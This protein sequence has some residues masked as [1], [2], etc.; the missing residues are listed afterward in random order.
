[1]APRKKLE[2]IVEMHSVSAVEEALAQCGA[3]GWSVF[4]G[5]QGAGEAGRW[6]QSGISATFEMCMIIAVVEEAVCSSVLERLAT[7]FEEYPGIVAVSDV[8]VI[9]GNKF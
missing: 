8:M 9:R 7:Y 1:M 4:S 2:V 5:T 3:K 6:R